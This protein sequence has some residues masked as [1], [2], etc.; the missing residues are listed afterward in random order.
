VGDEFKKET[1]IFM[2]SALLGTAVVAVVQY[3]TIATFSTALIVSAVS[4][5]VSIPI[6]AIFVNNLVHNEGV[7]FSRFKLVVVAIGYLASI[8][9]LCALFFHFAIWIGVVFVLGSIAALAAFENHPTR[10]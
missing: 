4:F 1:N 8:T 2:A 5:G 9:G 7:D 10:R 3:S 6:L